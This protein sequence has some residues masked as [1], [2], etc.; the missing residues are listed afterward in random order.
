MLTSRVSTLC[1]V[2]ALTRT[3]ALRRARGGFATSPRAAASGEGEGKALVLFCLGGP[4]AGK[5]TQCARLQ[6]EFGFAHLSAGDLLREERNSGS[7]VGEMI[8]SYIKDGRIVP[9]AVTLG[10]IRKAMEAAP[11]K[12]F[13]IDGFPRNLDNLEGWDG[14]M[15]DVA[16]VGGVLF[17]DC[18]HEEMQRRVLKRGETSGR[19]DDNAAAALKRVRVYEEATRPIIEHY[20]RA[21]KLISVDGAGDVEEVWRL[22]QEAVRPFV[23]E[24]AELSR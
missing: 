9:V 21:G 8:E 1:L 19:S 17:Y 15:A 14:S 3:C 23:R 12:R 4:G 16:D 10:L 18:S 7:D 24:A 11:T 13:V 20:E 22:T 5:G 2:H 6:E